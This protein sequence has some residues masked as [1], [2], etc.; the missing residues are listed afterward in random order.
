[1][2]QI[3]IRLRCNAMSE[4]LLAA[5]THA[6]HIAIRNAAPVSDLFVKET[7]KR[8]MGTV[9]PGALCLVNFAQREDPFMSYLKTPFT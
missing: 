7:S 5:D 8:C 2:T 6:R 3:V 1:M 9:T 4:R